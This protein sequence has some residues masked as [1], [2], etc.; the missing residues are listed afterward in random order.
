MLAGLLAGMLV[1]CTACGNGKNTVMSIKDSGNL[2]VNFLCLLASQ[3]KQL[4]KPVVDAYGNGDWNTV[5]VDENGT[6]FAD[7]VRQVTLD[8]AKNSLISEY[9]HD[10]VYGLTLSKEQQARLDA[11][12]NGYKT[13]YGGEAGLNN[14]LSAYGADVSTF[15]RYLELLSKQSALY[16]YLYGENGT[17]DLEEAVKTYFE[18]NYAIVTH[19]YFNIGYMEKDDGS[20]ITMPEEE[21]ARKRALAEELYNRVMAG[22]DFEALKA[23]YSEDL[24]E[25]EYYPDGFFVTNDT[26]FPTTFTTAAL[27]MQE[28]EYR[29]CE[30][31]GAGGTGLHLLYRKPMDATLYDHDETVYANIRN[32]IMADDLQNKM[33]AYEALVTVKEEALEKLDVSVI[34]EFSLTDETGNAQ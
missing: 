8:S 26:T 28:G 13:A 10:K 1:L 17:E 21:T 11:A 31:E 33:K 14:A 16:T 4:Y 32:R 6:T 18:E 9:M 15:R 23:Q 30:S 27:D 12:L 29:L 5:A 25:S 24:Y 22:E 34:P 3:Q 7:I 2:T 20:V 19:I